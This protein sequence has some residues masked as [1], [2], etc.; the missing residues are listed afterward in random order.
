MTLWRQ[1]FPRRPVSGS[2]FPINWEARPPVSA[3][4]VISQTWIL[5]LAII[6]AGKTLHHT[7]LI[8][9]FMYVHVCQENISKGRSMTPANK[10]WARAKR[11][12]LFAKELM[13][14]YALFKGELRSA[15][16]YR[17]GQ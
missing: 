16:K 7:L 11:H 8:F 6:S 2:L 10:K 5:S 17:K 15:Y 4:E 13:G 1:Q 9:H 3:N 12:L 14:C